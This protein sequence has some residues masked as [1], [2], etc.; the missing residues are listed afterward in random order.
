MN[1]DSEQSR[2]LW[3]EVRLPKFP[4][5]QQSSR[6]DVLVIGGGIAGLSTAYELVQSGR[7]VMVVDRGP[8]GGGMT[9]RT[10]AHLSYEIDDTY[11][12]LIA[13]HGER[14]ARLYFDSQK[15]AVDRIEEICSAE[16]MKCDF[17]RIDLFVFAPDK[18]GRNELE[19]EI[20]AAAKV[21]FAGVEWAKAPLKGSNRGCLRFPEQA[22]FHPLRYLAGLARAIKRDGGTLYANTPIVEIKETASGP[23]AKTE[24]GKTIRAKAIVAATNSPIA[25]RLAVH[26][27]QAPYR[28]YIVTLEAGTADVPDALIWDTDDPYHY[29]RSYQD[30]EEKLLLVGGED[31]KSGESDDF[32]PRLARLE[33]WAR[34]HFPGLGKVRHR[35]SGQIFEPA[36]YLPFIGRSPGHK[37][38]YIVSGDSGE[39]LTTG[40]AASLILPDLIA[41]RKNPWAAVYRPNRK[42]VQPSPLGTYVKDLA[43][44]T[45]HL[46]A[47]A[48][49]AETTPDKIGRNEGA[50]VTMGGKKIAAFRD[51]RGKLHTRSAACTH[52]GCVVKW[53]SF[54]RCW[55]CPCHG[56][57]FGPLGDVLQAPAMA[58]LRDGK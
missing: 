57:Q 35:W 8:I 42:I 49:Q 44:A 34:R 45:R 56:S 21:G 15:A 22:R 2:S 33:E 55:D 38:V 3:S 26:T 43:D 52:V 48:L 50:I 37:Q 16:R 6:T 31:H 47:H 18:K 39:G 51:G 4:Q 5:L 36:D 29:V 12:E 11:A 28:T 17:A 9:A 54:E 13:K 32:S 58:P 53:N 1:A 30:G 24:S 10:S 41:G 40:V 23:V 19:D 20:A 27:K 7:K 46:V 25:H 14:N